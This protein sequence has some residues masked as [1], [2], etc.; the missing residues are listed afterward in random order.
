MAR[1]V[2]SGLRR[3]DGSLLP[4]EALRGQGVALVCGIGRPRA[5]EAAMEQLLTLENLLALARA[6]AI[7]LPP[8]PAFY[9][10]PGTIEDQVDFIV[11]RVL[12]ALGIE[13]RLYRRWHEPE[14]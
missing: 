4:T 14:E 5:F 9:Q 12:D 10:K 3:G 2:F 6:G 1:E 7:V 13:N 11:S 8:C